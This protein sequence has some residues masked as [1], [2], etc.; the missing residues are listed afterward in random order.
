M[1]KP[2]ILRRAVVEKSEREQRTSRLADAAPRGWFRLLFPIS[3]QV[4][5]REE[6]ANTTGLKDALERRP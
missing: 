1:S 6:C 5:K 4:M 2:E 3:V